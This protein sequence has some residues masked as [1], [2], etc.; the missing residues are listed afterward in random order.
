MTDS[1]QTTTEL[2]RLR[3]CLESSWNNTSAPAVPPSRQSV[4]V[5]IKRATGKVC[6]GTYNRVWKRFETEYGTAVLDVVGWKPRYEQPAPGGRD[7]D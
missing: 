5:W 3:E 7:N 1:T 4:P 2:S 6:E